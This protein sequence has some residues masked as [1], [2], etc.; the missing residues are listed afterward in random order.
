MLKVIAG[1]VLSYF[2]EFPDFLD[3][4]FTRFAIKK[5]QTSTLLFA[6]HKKRILQKP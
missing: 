5:R 3:I 6:R 4:S 1:S 2:N